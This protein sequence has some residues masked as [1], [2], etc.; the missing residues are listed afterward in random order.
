MLQHS[1]SRK[2]WLQEGP[3][4]PPQATG[5]CKLLIRFCVH[6]R[7]CVLGAG[8]EFDQRW[9]LLLLLVLIFLVLVC[10]VQSKYIN[11]LLIHAC[12]CNQNSMARLLNQEEGSDDEF[13]KEHYGE[14]VFLEDDSEF[15]TEDEEDGVCVCVS[16]MQFLSFFLSFFFFRC[17]CLSFLSCCC[18]FVACTGACA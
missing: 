6:V 1:N 14:A 2:R 17:C 12:V 3:S 10:E 5:A 7:V 4:V 8:E 9:F 15:T 11:S 18:I 16:A 13:Y